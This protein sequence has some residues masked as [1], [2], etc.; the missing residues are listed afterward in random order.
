M[1]TTTE[2]FIPLKEP[3]VLLSLFKNR[4]FVCLTMVSGIGSMIFFALNLI[5]PQQIV[6]VWA[7][8]SETTGWMSVSGVFLCPHSS[9]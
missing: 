2:Y 9:L 8:P 4:N 7:E 5:Y 3:L 1:L 6:A